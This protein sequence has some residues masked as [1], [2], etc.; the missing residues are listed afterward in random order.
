MDMNRARIQLWLGALLAI[1]LAG[2]SSV[3]A[4]QA[5]PK[6]SPAPAKKPAPSKSASSSSQTAAKKP[7]AKR[8]TW[9]VPTYADSTANDIAEFDEPLVR[10]SAVA[11]LG[12]YNGSVVVVD[13]NSGRILSIVNQPLAFSEGFIPCSTIKPVIALAA[14]EQN[15]ITRDTMIRVGRRTYLNLTEAMAHSNNPFFENIGR[16]MGFETVAQYARMLG[17]GE[18]AGYNI[19]EEH[20]GQFP[21]APPANGGV[22]RMS[23]YGEG[24]HITPLQLASLGATFANGGTVFYLQYPRTEDERRNFL[25]RVKRKLNIEAL[26]PDLR[27]GML[28]TVLYGTGRSAFN[29]EGDTP[30]GKT[31]TCSENGTRLGWFVSY[32]DQLKPK[33]VVAVLIRGRSRVVGGHTAADIAGRVYTNLRLS[34]YLAQTASAIPVA[35]SGPQ[36]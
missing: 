25:P 17:L 35:T 28:A 12:R 10:A 30:L 1:L 18:P 21:S 19:F 32:A 26:L 3:W 4:R 6:K 14:L 34:G 33:V 29:P 13:P 22:G 23:S 9:G 8:R 24:I 2:M 36:R 31:G 7:A 5:T 20:P 15:V 16:K 27:E 11:A